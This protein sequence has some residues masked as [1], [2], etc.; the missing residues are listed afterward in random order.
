MRNERR[1]AVLRQPDFAYLPKRVRPQSIVRKPGNLLPVK[2]FVEVD[3]GSVCMIMKDN[4]V[5]QIIEVDGLDILAI[6]TT[7][8]TEF[9]NSL[10]AFLAETKFDMQLVVVTERSLLS[11][12]AYGKKAEDSE[13]DDA[14]IDWFGNY[15]EKWFAKVLECHFVPQR[16]FFLI[17]GNSALGAANIDGARRHVKAVMRWLASANRRPRLM[18]AASVRRLLYGLTHPFFQE[19]DIPAAVDTPV[20]LPAGVPAP[21]TIEERPNSLI[22]NGHHV[23]TMY[24]SYFAEKLDAG[25][26]MSL[27]TQCTPSVVS[28]H[29]RTTKSKENNLKHVS[30]YLSTNSETSS[31]LDNQSKSFSTLLRERGCTLLTA[32]S[33]Q[34]E[35]WLSCL[36]LGQ[37]LAQACNLVDVD[38]AAVFYPLLDDLACDNS[39]VPFGYTA[40]ARTP[41]FLD[42]LDASRRSDTLVLS[43]NPYRRGYFSTLL[44]TRLLPTRTGL[45]IWDG[46]GAMQRLIGALSS[47]MVS[48]WSASG[49]C[50]GNSLCYATGQKS[51][52]TEERVSQL[53]KFLKDMC[54]EH[55]SKNR[56]IIFIDEAAA[57]FHALPRKVWLSIQKRQ[58]SGGPVFVLLTDS[59]ILSGAPF[60][61]S[62]F[63]NVF[64]IQIQAN[65]RRRT[66]EVLKLSPYWKRQLNWV[67]TNKYDK[68]GLR[69]FWSG[70]NR[71]GV[72]RLV[73]SPMEY[74]LLR[75]GTE[76]RWSK[77]L[78]RLQKEHPALPQTDVVRRAAY[79]L[80]MES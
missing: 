42:L 66:A 54:S 67:T 23:R 29:F 38:T 78:E 16:R 21:A 68:T 8:L 71:A 48:R 49:G 80:G 11:S 30:L 6:D 25:F 24:L 72:L 75:P 45:A 79:Y 70:A 2:R 58:G 61:S 36:P 50:S 28:V 9:E 62:A 31:S 52:S 20:D 73:P 56:Q 47:D 10:A 37:D 7:S 59:E 41:V 46:N 55:A 13:N 17:T 44:A 51:M 34:Y 5:K 69:T 33:W 1:K 35:S 27:I 64:V 63:S 43:D 22:L 40:M 19:D 39:G 15:I 3:D 74:W 65:A 76:E 12:F 18:N 53:T 57:V 14:Y 4:S 32:R 77:E 60:A 26:L